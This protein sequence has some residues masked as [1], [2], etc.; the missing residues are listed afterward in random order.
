MIYSFEDYRH[1]PFLAADA[2][3]SLLRDGALRLFL[4]AGVSK[5][6]GLPDWRDL[7]ARML[8]RDDNPDFMAQ[9]KLMGELEQAKL[10]DDL[11][12]GSLDYLRKIHTALYRDV[13]S[14]LA[15]QLQ[16]SPLLLAVAALVTGSHRG[17]I[18]AVTTYNFD[19]VLEQYLSML[20]YSHCVRTAPDDLS[21]RADVAIDHPHGLVPQSWDR[22]SDLPQPVFSGKA[23]RHRRVGIDKGWSAT[24]NH[25]LQSK[26]G[27][28]LGLSGD[29]SAIVDVLSRADEQI[30][31]GHDY[32]GY[33]L[34]TPNAFT[35]NQKSIL[36]VGMCPISIK[37]E[38]MPDFVLRVCQR[39]ALP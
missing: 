9:L 16:K 7:I 37:K 2:L 34:M 33:W 30:C 27:L 39:A 4:G 35:R 13:E 5:G 15:R 23:Y 26:I 36:D 20:G 22:T 11:D 28:F 8:G 38:E 14:D 10:L 6:F 21:T 17:R 18:E 3:G 12:D 32:R 19:N 24:I 29:D 31:R 25:A 1:N